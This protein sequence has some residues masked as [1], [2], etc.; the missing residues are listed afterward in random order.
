MKKTILERVGMTIKHVRETFIADDEVRKSTQ[1]RLGMIV[2]KGRSTISNYETGEIN[3]KLQDIA[4]IFRVY[5]YDIVL[6]A[7]PNVA[8]K[9]VPKNKRLEKYTEWV[10]INRMLLDIDEEAVRKI[11]QSFG[12]DINI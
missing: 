2:G 11:L 10:T 1:E 4:N 12:H 3:M 5:G 9:D 7:L 6:F 8:L